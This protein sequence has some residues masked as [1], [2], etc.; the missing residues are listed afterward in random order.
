[1]YYVNKSGYILKEK[2]K[3]FGDWWCCDYNNN[4]SGELQNFDE[5]CQSFYTFE[6]AKEHS[7]RI[8]VI[9]LKRILYNKIQKIYNDD[10]EVFFDT[11]NKL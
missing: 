5:T 3:I 10:Y 6:E 11:Y 4:L 8:R 9:K 1:M 2:D 7:K